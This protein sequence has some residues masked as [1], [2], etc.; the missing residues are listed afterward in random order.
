MSRSIISICFLTIFLGFLV[1]PTVI[2]VI[3]NSI[4]VSF[5]FDSSEEEEK[6]SEKNEKNKNIEVLFFDINHNENDFASNETENS[7]E[8]CFK[9]YPKPHLN[10][11]SPPPELHIL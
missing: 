8:Y 4:D 9:N 3:D 6:G 7:L 5:F 10:L 11:I 1:T 2:S